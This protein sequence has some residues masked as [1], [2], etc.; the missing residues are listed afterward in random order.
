M[1][2]HAYSSVLDQA[3]HMF[4]ITDRTYQQGYSPPLPQYVDIQWLDIG[5]Q[6]LYS[7]FKSTNTESCRPVVN[8]ADQETSKHHVEFFFKKKRVKYYWSGDQPP[9]PVPS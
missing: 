4:S 8:Q 9:S 5:K 1:N 2:Y 6:H 3:F 7:Y